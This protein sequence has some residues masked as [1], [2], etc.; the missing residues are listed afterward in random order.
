MTRQE[1]KIRILKYHEA[2]KLRRSIKN[3][4]CTWV[5]PFLLR[6]RYQKQPDVHCNVF[7]SC[8][9]FCRPL[10]LVCAP[11][12]VESLLLKEKNPGKRMRLNEAKVNKSATLM[13]NFWKKIG[14]FILIWQLVLV[15]A[16]DIV[17]SL[18]LKKNGKTN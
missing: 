18:R 2:S 3:L 16:P 8:K 14:Y 15:Y 9:L 10:A 7:G 13:S 11:D 5:Y 1:E 17:E 12:I 6:C 4:P